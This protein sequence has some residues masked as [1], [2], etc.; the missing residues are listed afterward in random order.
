MRVKQGD[1]PPQVGS[2]RL[3]YRIVGSSEKENVGKRNVRTNKD[4]V[5]SCI[6]AL[7]GEILETRQI[8]ARVGSWD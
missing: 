1:L 8:T 2:V 5:T 7:Q 6:K 4:S 3:T